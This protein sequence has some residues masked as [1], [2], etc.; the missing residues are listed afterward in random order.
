MGG[1]QLVL[2]LPCGP[3]PPPAGVTGTERKKDILSHYFN[4]QSS[5]SRK[6]VPKEDPL[7]NGVH[8]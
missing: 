8:S 7:V 3:T 2:G 6:M 4:L 5:L 1:G